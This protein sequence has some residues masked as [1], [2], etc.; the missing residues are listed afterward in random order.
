[1][2]KMRGVPMTNQKGHSNWWNA[3]YRSPDQEICA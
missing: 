3:K 1:M 2:A